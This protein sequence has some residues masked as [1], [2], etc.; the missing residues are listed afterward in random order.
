MGR[1]I[2]N[3]KNNFFEL[4]KDK[5]HG[6]LKQEKKPKNAM[7]LKRFLFIMSFSTVICWLAWST[8]LFF[9]DP[10]HS[11]W[12]GPLSF[13][14]SLFFALLGTFALVGFLLRWA[15]IRKE[16]AFRHIGISLRQ[17]SLLALFVIMTLLLQAEKIF[18]WWS[19]ALLLFGFAIL[20]IFFFLRHSERK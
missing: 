1:T 8:V 17:G 12:I 18:V 3:R 13:Y 19:L 10:F 7:P 20:E 15:L 4:Q 11:G 16:P 2:G 5:K 6:I 9:I 14:A